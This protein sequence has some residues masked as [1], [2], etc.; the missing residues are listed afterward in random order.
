MGAWHCAN[1]KPQQQFLLKYVAW[2]NCTKE[3]GCESVQCWRGRRLGHYYGIHYRWSAN[4][5]PKWL[6]TSNFSKE[7]EGFWRSH[8]LSL[9]LTLPKVSFQVLLNSIDFR[10][11]S[12]C[13]F[14]CLMTTFSG[15][16]SSNT[17]HMPTRY[18]LIDPWESVLLSLSLFSSSLRFLIDMMLISEIKIGA[19]KPLA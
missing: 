13:L 2:F 18:L 1:V 4:F 17:F 11:L 16:V 12:V 8:V 14:V 3:P 10:H 15:R 5:H 9:S 6:F 19:Q 7:T